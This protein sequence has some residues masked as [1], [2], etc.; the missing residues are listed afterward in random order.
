MSGTDLIET[1][2]ERLRQAMLASD[3]EALDDLLSDELIFTDHEGRRLSK[4]DDLAAHRSGA[5]VIETIDRASD[6]VIH[7]MGNVATVCVDVD[8]A[9]TYEAS[10]FFGR[11]AYARVW[12]FAEGGWKVVLAHCSAVP[13]TS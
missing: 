6:A 11:F 3:V 8:I 5:L 4:S 2:E 13:A 10:A 1:C 9:G 12:Q 7:Q